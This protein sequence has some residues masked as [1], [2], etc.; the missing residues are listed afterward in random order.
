MFVS[1]SAKATTK[2]NSE[3]LT[4]LLPLAYTASCQKKIETYHS[5]FIARAEPISWSAFHF[6][7]VLFLLFPIRSNRL[8]PREENR[9]A[10]CAF[11]LCW[12]EISGAI[13]F[14]LFRARCSNLGVTCDTF[15]DECL[16]L[17]VIALGIS[18]H[19]DCTGTREGSE[20]NQRDSE[21]KDCFYRSPCLMIITIFS[22]YFFINLCPLKFEASFI[23]QYLFD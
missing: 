17:K 1:R 9:R 20:T 19:F 8:H 13:L 14:S 16:V 3:I 4:F 12:L 2:T 5:K 23:R 11:P 22:F 15:N 18:F 21:W 10:Y 7:F 6:R